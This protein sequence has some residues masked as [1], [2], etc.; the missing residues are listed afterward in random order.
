MTPLWLFVGACQTIYLFL[1]MDMFFPTQLKDFYRHLGVM[2]MI[3]WKLMEG[4]FGEWFNVWRSSFYYIWDKSEYPFGI[5]PLA[6]PENPVTNTTTR[7]LVI[8]G[9]QFGGL[10]DRFEDA[11]W[12]SHSAI[13]NSIDILVAIP[14]FLCLGLVLKGLTMAN[15]YS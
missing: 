4:W 15:R 2:S 3:E 13:V 10:T 14:V 7:N 9:D 8:A 12:A 5:D 6:Y 11:G 1:T